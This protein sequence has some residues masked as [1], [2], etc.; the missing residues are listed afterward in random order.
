MSIAMLKTVGSG[1]LPEADIEAARDAS[2]ALARLGSRGGVHVQ[3]EEGGERQDFVLPATAVR[4]LTDMLS[5]L[6]QGRSV[7]V[8]PED[9]ELTT[10]QA[11]DMLNVSRPYLIRLLEDGTLPH[12]KTGTHRRVRLHDLMA[13]RAQRAAESQAALDELTRQAQ[14]LGMGY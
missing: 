1:L 4:L 11:A 10:Q 8:M 6:A 7:V 9:A 5:L 14:E 3:A 2:R 13:Y 12:H